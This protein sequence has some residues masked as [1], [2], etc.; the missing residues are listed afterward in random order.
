MNEP[1]LI[2]DEKFPSSP[3]EEVQLVER[4]SH[5]TFFQAKKGNE[6]QYFFD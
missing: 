2:F 1:S 3:E 6:E 4:T 5:H